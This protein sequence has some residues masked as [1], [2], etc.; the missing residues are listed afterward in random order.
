MWDP[1]TTDGLIV[2]QSFTSH[3][4]WVSAVKW[5]V[6]DSNLFVSCSY[7][8]TFKE[9]DI[10]STVPLA[11]VNAH[12]DKA[13]CIDYHESSD[14]TSVLTGGADNQVQSFTL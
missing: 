8:G 13:L 14:K 4:Q 7:D 2:K 11:T 9:W 5:N 6:K 1:R 12:S 10:R 3:S